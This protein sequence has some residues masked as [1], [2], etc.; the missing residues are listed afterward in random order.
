MERL[1]IST[2][3]LEDQTYTVSVTGE[4][5]LATGARLE[6]ALAHV[7]T[8][9][10][11]FVIAD[12]SRV[13]HFDASALGRLLAVH[14]RLAALG[15]TFAIVCSGRLRS[16]LRRTA[17]DEILLVCDVHDGVPHGSTSSS[18]TPELVGALLA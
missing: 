7:V 17:L 9:G 15:G 8:D 6:Q 11:R 2:G 14:D 13:T 3:R 4:I 1:A 5:G 10:A 12:L 16:V 18:V